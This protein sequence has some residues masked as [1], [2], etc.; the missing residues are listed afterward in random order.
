M[1]AILRQRLFPAFLLAVT[2]TANLLSM[3]PGRADDDAITLDSASE[4]KDCLLL[5][6]RR[7]DQAFDSATAWEKQGGGDA[8]RHCKALALINLDRPE[9]GA[10]ELERI[11]QT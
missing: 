4:Y 10:L 1:D 7:P 11:A 3:Q 2:L 6:Q 9:D 5:A 8:A